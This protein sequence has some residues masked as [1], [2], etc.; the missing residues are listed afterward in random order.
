M[1][2]EGIYMSINVNY[3]SPI[4]SVSKLMTKV[5]GFEK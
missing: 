1:S 4:S 3:E 5:K 2:L